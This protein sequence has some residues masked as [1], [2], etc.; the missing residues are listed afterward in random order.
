MTRKV[1]PDPDGWSYTARMKRA[2]EDERP[3]CPTCKEMA[4]SGVGVATFE[5]GG[6]TSASTWEC[7]RGH[8][9]IPVYHCFVCSRVIKQDEEGL[10]RTEGML[11]SG[12]KAWEWGPVPVHD[13]C[14]LNLKTPLDDQDGYMSAWQLMK[15]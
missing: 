14:R 1:V 2:D 6:A 3:I 4:I 5:G 15:P 13:D 11:K 12:T 8:G 9:I 10:I 7:P